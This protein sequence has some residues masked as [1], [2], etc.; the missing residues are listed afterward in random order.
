ML[1]ISI[2]YRTFIRGVYD[3]YFGSE[4]ENIMH[5]NMRQTYM[6]EHTIVV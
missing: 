5:Q 2:E 4:Y 6:C 3:A 1:Q